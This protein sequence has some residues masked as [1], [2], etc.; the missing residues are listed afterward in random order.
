MAFPNAPSDRN[1]PPRAVLG[2]D[3]TCISGIRLRNM[4]TSCSGVGPWGRGD[5]LSV[6]A[7]R[8][9]AVCIFYSLFLCA[10]VHPIR[11]RPAQASRAKQAKRIFIATIII[12]IIYSHYHECR[13]TLHCTCLPVS[14]SSTIM[15]RYIMYNTHG[16]GRPGA[17]RKHTYS[18]LHQTPCR[19][20]TR[21]LT[22]AVFYYNV[23]SLYC[24]YYKYENISVSYI[25]VSARFGG[26][27]KPTSG[28]DPPAGPLSPA[29]TRDPARCCRSC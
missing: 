25:S 24:M 28:K 15:V 9:C 16:P 7:R 2:C 18:S 26:T 23:Y 12:I 4:W 20:R 11:D 1:I 6:G 19:S 22:Q 17:L 8:C 14:R 21:G 5:V 13:S 3:G 10:S 27:R 29:R